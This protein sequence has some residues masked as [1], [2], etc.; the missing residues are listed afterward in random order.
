DIALQLGYLY[1]DRE[2][3]SA[4]RALWERYAAA[5]TRPGTRDAYTYGELAYLIGEYDEALVAYDAVIRQLPANTPITSDVPRYV[6]GHVANIHEI[7]G[8]DENA[9]RV[10][11]QIDPG[12]GI[13]GEPAP[14][15]RGSVDSGEL[16][17]LSELNAD[18][19]VLA[20]WMSRSP[21]SQEALRALAEMDDEYD[22]RV[23]FVALNMQPNPGEEKVFASVYVPFH[24][25]YEMS[26]MFKEY[27]IV[28]LPTI[29]HID[30]NG[31]VRYRHMGYRSE[32]IPDIKRRIDTL[33]NETSASVSE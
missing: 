3:V 18:V 29:V 31:V 22:E 13:V 33:L 15:F 7:N 16:F 25:L 12:M 32:E 9:K 11:E 5:T 23:A 21:Y 30:R 17:Q 19:V 2:D 14:D 4:I 8:N 20:F 10:L 24:A 1:R 27:R 26:E 28:S 6:L